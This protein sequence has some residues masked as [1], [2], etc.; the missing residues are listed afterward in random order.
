MLCINLF[1]L[2]NKFRLEL[3][4]NY[5]MTQFSMKKGRKTVLV[6]TVL[7]IVFDLLYLVHMV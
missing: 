4:I 6:N 3:Y 5:V 2:Y 7:N 1:D